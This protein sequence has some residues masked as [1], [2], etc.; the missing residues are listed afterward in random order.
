MALYVAMAASYTTISGWVNGSTVRH[1]GQKTSSV[2]VAE[3]IFRWLAQSGVLSCTSRREKTFVRGDAT[4]M[5]ELQAV[6]GF[7]G[8]V[9]HSVCVQ[10][11]EYG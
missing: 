2:S 7:H 9:K 6:P 10:S 1:E 3:S 8:A 11:N 5:E 4:V